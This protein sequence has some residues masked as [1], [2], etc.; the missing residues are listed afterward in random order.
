MESKRNNVIFVSGQRGSGKSYWV[1][2]HLRNLPRFIIYDSLSEYDIG[3][4]TDNFND[5]IKLLK[6]KGLM[7]IAYDPLDVTDF[8]LVCKAVY[9]LE[10]LCFVVEE[11]DQFATPS[12]IPPDLARILKYGRHKEIDFIGVSRRPAETSRL[13]TSQANR[14]II[15][16]QHEPRDISYFKSFIG[17][18]A[19]SLKTLKAH[20]HLDVSW[21][22]G[23]PSIKNTKI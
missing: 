12:R 19:D 20:Y 5:F 16:R 6:D 22:T 10:N 14:F 3:E 23:E 18:Q 8:D 2:S 13:L 21:G 17:P 9:R 7:R 11:V 15:F 1:K 4:R